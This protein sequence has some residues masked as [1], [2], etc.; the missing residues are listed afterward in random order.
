M[1]LAAIFNG[2]PKTTGSVDAIEQK[3]M[4]LGTIK[5]SETQKISGKLLEISETY[6]KDVRL[7]A[8]RSFNAAL[9]VASVGM[10]IFFVAVVLFMAGQSD[11]GTLAVV[12]SAIPEIISGVVFYLYFRTM[13]Q[14]GYFHVCLERM[15]RYL[16]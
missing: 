7:Q 1:G 14:F 8:T 6:Y 9:L 10:V 16:T 15:N 12:A 13:R 5:L 4:D 2:L 3:C 11:K